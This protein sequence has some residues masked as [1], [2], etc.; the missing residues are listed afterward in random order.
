[1]SEFIKNSLPETGLVRLNQIIGNR[2]QGIWPPVIPVSKSC[3]WEGVKTGRY[4][5]AIKLSDRVTCWRA[6]EI[7]AF[8]DREV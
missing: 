5:A 4:P 1:M 8:L 2:K 7:R 6:E 3:W